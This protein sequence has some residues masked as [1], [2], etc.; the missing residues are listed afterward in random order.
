M[1]F[2]AADVMRK[3]STIL[4]DA[5]AVRWPLTELLDWINSA[6]REIAL[7]KPTATAETIGISLES[8][9]KQSI[10]AGYH[11]I[12][13]VLRNSASGRSIT[14]TTREIID[15]QLPGWHDTSILPFSVDV[16]HFIN[17]GDDQR[18][19]FVVPGNTGTGVIDVVASKVPAE[20]ARPTNPLSIAEYD[21]A[22]PVPDIYQSAVID[23]VLYR[24]FSKDASVPGAA[25]RA[26][27]YYQ[28]FANALGLKVQLE[29]TQ[30]PDAPQNRFSI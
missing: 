13:R 24:A 21:D 27:A 2:T 29:Q 5:G 16:V 23:Y 9:T 3:A 14:P 28:Q 7:L 6:T 25:Q 18:S 1:A 11:Q 17:E 30:T 10:P 20:I 4:N 22:V 15:T 12:L 19:F 8:G 26:S